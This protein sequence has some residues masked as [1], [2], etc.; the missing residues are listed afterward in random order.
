[1]ITAAQRRARLAVRHGLATA[2]RRDSVEEAARSVVALHATEPA[3]VYLAVAARS[4][5]S[6]DDVDRALY[7][8]RTVVK[9]LAMRRTLFGFPRELLPAA[10]GSAGARVAGQQRRLLAREV[11]KAGI[12]RDG[13]RW[14]EVACAAVLER[15]AD[16]SALGA[17]ELRERL[18]ELAGQMTYAVGTSYGGT[19]HIAPRV[20]TLL[21]AEGRIVRAEN[22]GHWRTSRPT[23]T[24]MSAWLGGPA[25]PLEARAGYAELVRRWLAAFGP[26]TE[27]DLVW[28]LGATKKVVQIGR[29]HV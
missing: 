23:W 20:L 28:W 24:A 13:D 25:D 14:V 17:R 5:C 15:L 22:A 10:W 11:E 19:I 27:R 3:T 4:A 18:P 16:G 1:V 7:T 21:G 8:D 12:A 29:A 6:V 2:Y 26:G 9:Q